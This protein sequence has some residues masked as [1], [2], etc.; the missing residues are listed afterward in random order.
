LGKKPTATRHQKEHKDRE[1]KPVELMLLV[2][3][4]QAAISVI[5]PAH[6]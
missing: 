4:E 5:V 1:E 2:L 3:L 6:G